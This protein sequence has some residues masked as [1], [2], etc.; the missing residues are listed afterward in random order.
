ME[1]DTQLTDY[2][3]TTYLQGNYMTTRSITEA[4]MNNDASI[5]FLVDN[6]YDKT[7]LDNKI[8]GLGSTDCL[9][10]KNVLIVLIHPHIM[11][12]NLKLIIY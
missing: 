3:T 12:I 2:V 5:T 11:I 7:Y 9:N 1:I 10:F 6:I 8:T 4:L